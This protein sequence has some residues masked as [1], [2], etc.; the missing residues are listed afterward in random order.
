MFTFQS[1]LMANRASERE[2]LRK[3]RSPGWLNRTERSGSRVDA[4]DDVV[5]DVVSAKP[6][7]GRIASAGKRTAV[8]RTQRAQR[9]GVAR[10]DGAPPRSVGP[11]APRRLASAV[12]CPPV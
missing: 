5:V 6:T 8:T 11:A 2:V 9:R 1:S 12:M 7:D 3:V 4:A 10:R